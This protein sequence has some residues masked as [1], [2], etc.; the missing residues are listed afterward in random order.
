MSAGSGHTAAPILI[1][2]QKGEQNQE[3]K[4]LC[5]LLAALLWKK[6]LKI[7]FGYGNKLQKPVGGYFIFPGVIPPLPDIG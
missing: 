1:G 6:I 7:G 2:R 4:K 5:A 3:R